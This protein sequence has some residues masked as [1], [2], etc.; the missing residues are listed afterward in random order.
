MRLNTRFAVTLLLGLLLSFF[1]ETAKA[2]VVPIQ[3]Y[4]A[5]IL[6]ALD[7]AQ[8]GE[9]IM[10]PLESWRKVQGL[11][12]L[13]IK[14]RQKIGRSEI[15][16]MRQVFHKR[17]EKDSYP[18][19]RCFDPRHAVLLNVGEKAPAILWICFE[20]DRFSFSQTKLS[21][22]GFPPTW[23][24]YLEKFFKDNGFPLKPENEG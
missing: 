8:D 19:A 11:A 9:L 14:Q 2:E 12:G 22:E 21:T 20:C 1:C 17:L 13:D 16:A 10:F 7:K 5:D 23:L 15:E 6:E 18:G 24:A 3:T 4:Q